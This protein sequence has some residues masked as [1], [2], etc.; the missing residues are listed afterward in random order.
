[1]GEGLVE[2]GDEVFDVFDSDG[3]A[4]EAVGDADMFAEFGGSGLTRGSSDFC[5]ALIPWPGTVS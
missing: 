4:D 1:M 5:P 3:E 2:V